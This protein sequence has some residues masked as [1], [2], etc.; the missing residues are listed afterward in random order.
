MTDTLPSDHLGIGCMLKPPPELVVFTYNCGGMF[1]DEEGFG[2]LEFFPLTR[3]GQ[4]YVN[5]VEEVLI[6]E[7]VR[8][9]VDPRVFQEMVEAMVDGYADKER[10]IAVMSEE[11]RSVESKLLMKP[12]Q[13]QVVPDPNKPGK[14]I[15]K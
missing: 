8:N 14:Q 6:T 11:Y 4:P 1:A 13:A 10:M 5:A 3:E 12:Y 9:M 2:S 7:T 15:R